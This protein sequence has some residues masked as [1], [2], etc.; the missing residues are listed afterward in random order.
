MDLRSERGAIS[1]A[2]G[3][4]FFAM[5][6][7]AVLLIGMLVIAFFRFQE[8]PQNVP[9]GG[10][11]PVGFRLRGAGFQQDWHLATGDPRP[12]EPPHG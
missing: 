5:F 12:E 3:C 8:P 10:P 1:G 2:E 9:I 11:P 7:F 4:M 6:F